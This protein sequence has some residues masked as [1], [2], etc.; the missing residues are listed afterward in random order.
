MGCCE[1]RG[2]MMTFFDTGCLFPHIPRL[3]T[4]REGRGSLSAKGEVASLAKPQASYRRSSLLST[5]AE[6]MAD[7]FTSCSVALEQIYRF[8]DKF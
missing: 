6:M 2:V 4:A 5:H 8:C 1:C 3:P 7:E